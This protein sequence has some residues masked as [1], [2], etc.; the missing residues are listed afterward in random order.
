MR[1]AGNGPTEEELVGNH[2]GGV[3][4]GVEELG[5]VALCFQTRYA[6]REGD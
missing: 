2:F 1:V 4:H 6:A 5:D 3:D